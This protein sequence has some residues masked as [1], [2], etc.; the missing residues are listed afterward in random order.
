YI[1]VIL[2]FICSSILMMLVY[3]CF[4]LIPFGGRTVLRMDLFHQYGPLFGELYDRL[5]HFKNFM[6]SW[7]TGG[8]GSFL[9]NYYN[10]LSSP[11]GDI[12]A[13]IAGHEHIPEAIGAMVLVKNALASSMLALYLKKSSGRNDFT[14]S[15]FGVMYSFCGFFIAYYWNIMWI[16][17]LYLLPLVVLGIE[18]IIS[19]KKCKLYVVALALAFFSNYYM[20]YMIC[21]FSVLY[22]LVYFISHNEFMDSYAQLNKDERSL[23]ASVQALYHNKFLHSGVL[24][25]AS[26]L[27]A[28]MLV[29]FAVI[30]TYFCLKECSAT[31]GTFPKEAVF[32]NNIF[33]FLA[34]HLA[35]LEPTIRSSGDTV[36][37]NVYCG[38]LTL[39][40]VP[41]YIFCDKISSKERAAHIILLAIFFVGFNL[42]QANYILHAFHFPN[43]L[44]FRFSFLYSFT[45]VIM[46]FKALTHIK[47]ISPKAILGSALGVIGLAVLVQKTGM[48]NVSDETVYVSI[49]MAVVYC[50]VLGLMRKKNYSQ[51]TV[52]LLLLCCVFAEAAIANTNHFEITQEKVNFTNGYTEFRQL[53]KKLDNIE[54]TD[55]YR[56]DLSDINT[57][58]D[59]SW[60]NY[61]GLSVFSSMAYE[62]SSNLQDRLGMDSN[63]INSYV[64]HPQ[65]PVYNAMMS[66]KYLINNDNSAI[67]EKLY[68]FVT[69]NGKFSA[70]ENNYYMPIMYTV[71]KDM[72]SL[73][74]DSTNP[75]DVQNDFWAKATGVEK[76]F[77]PIYTSNHTAQN[78][79][80]E[81]IDYSCEGFPY[82]KVVIGEEATI[83]LNYKI[84]KSQNVYVYFDS[85][86]I[87]NI[88][89]STDNGFT[90][91][92][93]TDESYILDCGYC[94]EGTTLSVEI[95][96]KEDNDSGSINCYVSGLD[97]N[98][99][100]AGYEV[101][102]S[103]AATI[104]QFDDTYIKADVNVAK[105]K[106]IYT[107]INYD[108]G[109]TVTVD[110][111]K[112]TPCRIGDALIG[113]NV[114][115][116]KHTVELKYT[117]KGLSIGIII[118]AGTAALLIAYL[119]AST[120]I[121]NKKEKKAKMLAHPDY[122]S[123]NNGEPTGIDAMMEQDLGK[124]AT[125]EQA[126]ALLE[127]P[128]EYEL[129]K[130]DTDSTMKRADDILNTQKLNL[131]EI[132][133]ML[134]KTEKGQMEDK[135]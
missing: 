11:I 47:D 22:F 102:K 94:V 79:D 133:D 21:I 66:L 40:L 50:V 110:G 95:P 49:G 60:F 117:P 84:E 43:D 57:L 27:I 35:S 56:M 122:Y 61:N 109:W 96:I 68:T 113:I 7:N 103:G 44:P 8:G 16:D 130:P 63:Y 38:V 72:T 30:P 17:A 128:D 85:S 108:D 78:I 58:M 99:L 89:V 91:N 118:S 54:K 9:G 1:Y 33:D 19:E 25:A 71:S 123:V 86:D 126:E 124:N 15:A 106:L 88:T 46:A 83:T 14:I 36:L 119:I 97:M 132:R 75:F 107:S 34:N 129:N 105:N 76:V 42:N 37:P 104:K 116:G 127:V 24:F 69:S 73:N 64:Y 98:A 41:L 53:K 82:N 51:S 4:D 31:S 6:Y 39:V 23:K 80:D 77:K 29:A 87:E 20:A 112:T 18:K 62:K 111:K 5:A 52:A 10:Y 70:Y 65:T 48:E 2:A 93:S 59:A 12:I 114:E 74:T 67:N 125:I 121:N 26:S 115:P 135:D 101:L 55:K 45:L 120:I 81:G 28:V 13:L 90:K 134:E 92:Q 32:Y 100:D 3:Y 131:Q